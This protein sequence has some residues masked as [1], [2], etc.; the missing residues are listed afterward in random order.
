LALGPV[1]AA[2]GA[3]L[4]AA[5]A[6]AVA[7]GVTAAATAASVATA[8]PAHAQSGEQVLVL[9]QNGE[10]NAPE[11]ALLQAAGYSVTEATPSVWAGMSTA[12]FEGYAALVIGDPSSAG[13][14]S[15]LL[16]TTGTSGSDAL[17][18]AWQAAVNGNV[19]VLGTAP[20]LPGTSA[21]DSLITDSVEYAAAGWN[22]ANSGSN[23]SDTGL[24]VSLNCEYATATAGTD[25]SLLDGVEGIGT[26][27]GLT[28]QGN[29]ACGD[30]G[31]VNTWEVA[32]AGTYSGFTSSDLA[33][34]AWG[35]ACPVQEA[36][37]SWP[38]MFNPVAYDAASDVT[39]NFTASDGGTGQPYV[40]L[41][42]P[43]SSATAALAPSVGG[44]VLGGTTSGGT[45]NP[46]APGVDQAAAGD[47]VNTENGDFT[48]SDADLSLPGF[49]PALNFSR[50]YDANLAQQQTQTQTPGPMGY[51]WT[52]NWATS[53]STARPTPGDIY[54]AD[55]MRLDGG[56][57]GL[58]VGSL[59]TSPEGVY[60]ASN[61]DVY[62]ADTGDNRIQEIAASNESEWGINMTAN[63]V[64]TVAGQA[65]GQD[66]LPQ[67]QGHANGLPA[68]SI[69]LNHP[70]GITL[71][72]EG[73]LI[74]TDTNNARIVEIAANNQ[75]Q[76]GIS[77][78]AGDAYTIAGN[79]GVS[80]QGGLDG[81]AT[82][83]DLVDPTSVHM[84]QGSGV[85]D[86]YIADGSGNRILVMPGENESAEWGQS[87]SWTGGY[88]YQVAGDG[89]PGVC[90]NGRAAAGACL[91]DPQGV[92]I[93]GT[94]MYIAD[95][96]NNRIV[97]VPGTS[98]S[99][100]WGV[101]ASMTEGD[102]YTV[103][104]M[105]GGAGGAD[106]SGAKAIGDDLSLPTAVRD[107]N[108]NLYITDSGNSDVVEVA[109]STHSEWGLN[110]TADYLYQVQ[111]WESPAD[112]D[113][114]WVD[115][116]GDIYVPVAAQDCV[117]VVE[118]PTPLDSHLIAGGNRSGDVGPPTL[119]NAGDDG[120]AVN[121]SL[122][123]PTA[124]A[125]DSHGDVYIADA[126]NERV[127]EIAAY[128]HTQFGIA[129]LAGDTYTIAS[130]TGG[131]ADT[132]PAVTLVNPVGLAVDSSGDVYIADADTYT[133]DVLDPA[134]N[135]SVFAG[136]GNSG[137]FSGNGTAAAGATLGAPSAVAVDASGDV[138]I[139]DSGNNGVLEVPATTTSQMTAG[140]IYAVAGAA[141]TTPSGLS[142]TGTTTTSVSLSW[143]ASTGTVTGYAVYENGATTP[144]TTTSG[145][146]TTA[147]VTGLS[148]STTYTFTVAA[149]GVGGIAGSQST[150]VTATTNMLPPAPP[151]G[152]TVTGTTD[153]S[154]SLSW[155]APSGT[156]SGYNVYENGGS[157]VVATST[158]TSATVTGLSAST[159][160]TFTVEATNPGGSSTLSASVSAATAPPPPAAP[161]G[162]TV[163]GTMSTTVSLSWTAPSG[164]VTGYY[165]YQ[166][167]QTLAGSVEEQLPDVTV[168][169]TTAVVAGLSKSTSY[170]LN[171]AAYNV[172]GAGSYS[173]TVTARTGSTSAPG[174]PTGL[175]VSGVTSSSV[176][177]S[178]TAPSGTVTGYYVY[179]NGG[180]ASVASSTSTS[181]TVAGLSASTT[182]TFT[183]AAYN[184]GG[185]GTTSSSV[186][187][188]TS[189]PPVAPGAPAGL[190]VT[191]SND[192][193][194]SLSWTAPPGTVTGYYV[195]ENGGAVSV[196]ASTSTSVT[197]TG[198][199]VSTGYTF[200]VAAY[201]SAGTGTSSS[202]VPA[203]T[204]ALPGAPSGLTVTG[205]TSGSVS[206]SWT[207]PP[208]TV[209]GYYV[210]EN[211]GSTSVASS[212]STSVTVTGLTVSTTYTFTVA[213]YDANGAS[214]QSSP[215]SATTGAAS[216]P[217]APT[218]LT[219]TLVTDTSVS[220][221]WTAP[222]GTVTGYYVYEED[223]DVTEC[224]G[225][226][227]KVATVTGTGTT[228]SGLTEFDMYGFAVAAYNSAGTGAETSEVYVETG[229]PLAVKAGS[230]TQ[231]A[232][233]AGLSA[234]PASATS[235]TLT[236][237]KPASTTFGGYYVYE[238]GTEVTTVSSA[239]VSS[240]TVSGLA[241]ATKYKFSI[242]EY[243]G[244]STGAQSSPATATT[245]AS[246]GKTSAVVPLY[247]GGASDS[248]GSTGNGGPATAALLDGPAGIA[249]DPAG[250][251]YISDS[252]NNEIR[253]IAAATGTQHGQAMTAGDIYAVAGNSTTTVTGAAC[254]AYVSANGDQG[255]AV[256][257]ALYGPEQVAVDQAGDL[258]IADTGNAVIREVPAAS[259]TQ[260]SQSMTAG[261]IYDIAGVD[262]N[263]GASDSTG[264]GSTA[265][266]TFMN[267]PYGMS[268][269][270]YGDL[271]ILQQGGGPNGLVPQLQEI[272]ATAT[273]SIP[274]GSGQTSSLYPLDTPGGG[275][276]ITIAQPGDSQV[277]F[278]AQLPTG[279]CPSGYNQVDSY[280]LSGQDT[281]ATLTSNSGGNWVY[282]PTA[283]GDS[284]TYPQSGGQMISETDTAGITLTITQ[285]TPA[286]GS[287]QCPSTAASCETIL[288]A[289]GRTL[290]VGSS[291]A[292]LITS[293]TDPMGRS[294]SYQ[295]NSADQL[296]SATDPMTNVTSYTYGAGTDTNQD[297]ANDLLTIT[298]PNGQ[299]GGPDAG[300]STI[301][302]YDNLGRVV[303]Q[304]DPMG[305]KTSFNYCVNFYDGDCMDPASGS[306]YVTVTDPDNNK[307]IY[308]YTSGTLAS[309]AQYTAAVVTSEHDYDPL[310]WVGVP[311]GGTLLDISTTDGDGNTTTYAYNTLG[312]V[313]STTAP[314]PD[315]PAVTSSSYT[316][317]EDADCVGTPETP[318]SSTCVNDTGPSPVEP[319]G[320]IT[321]PSTG[322]PEGLAFTLYDTDGN[323]LYTTTG[324]YEPGSS[325]AAYFQTNYQLFNGNTVAL[326]GTTI[327]CA[328]KAPAPSLPCAQINA[329]Y[330]VTQLVYDA[331]GD[332]ISSST[333]DGNGAEIATSAN[334]YNADGEL[335]STTTPDGNLSGANA[336][337]Y[338]T[339][340]AYNADGEKT[341]ITQAGGSG[342]TATPRVITYTYDGD[343]DQ[344]GVK[345]G[346][347]YTTTTIY[348][349]DDKPSLVTN[350]D[351]DATL[352][353]YD[354]DGNTA[355]TVPPV[356]V[357]ANS[358]TASSCPT[359][360]PS[361]YGVRLVADAT[362]AT[363]NVAREQVQQATPAPAGQSG[364]EITTYAYDGAGNTVE[365]DAPPAMSGGLN[366]ITID[367]YNSANQ[368]A[369]QTVGYGISA[370]STTTFCYNPN[371]DRTAVVAPD[372]NTS[373]IAACEGASPWIVNPSTNP[374]Q[375]AY[376]TT[377]SYDSDDELVT[378]TAP[379]S[380][381][382]PNGATTTYTY[383][384]AG[385]PLTSTDPDNITTTYTYTP[386][387]KQAKI[388]Y[389]GSAAA[390]ITFSYDADGDKTA[391]TDTSGNST[392]QYDPFGELTQVTNGANETV[393]YNYDSD[394]DVTSIGYPLPSTATWAQ[395]GSATFGY[396]EADKLNTITD[397]SDNTITV[398]D[399]ADGLPASEKLGSSGDTIT[400][401][402]DSAGSPSTIALAN[403]GGTLQSFNYADA[404]SGNILT[405]TDTPSSAGTPLGYGYDAQGRVTSNTPGNETADDYQYDASGNLTTLPNGAAGTYNQAS[406]L[407]SATFTGAV[408]S[409]TYNADGE[410]LAV[411][412]GG[413]TTASGTWNGAKEVTAYDDSSAQMAGAT[414]DG[415][416]LRASA[417]FTPAN[418][419]A[420]T[421]SY[422]W[423]GDRLLMDSA[424]AYIYGNGSAPAEQVNL[425][426]GTIDY[427]VSD[428]L[429][430]VR[431][432]VNSSGAL[433]GTTSYDAWGNSVSNGGLK[434][435]TPFGFAGGYTD[436][437]GLVYLI[438]R[439]YDP[440]S[441]QFLSAD[442]EVSETEQPYAYSDDDPA[443]STDPSGMF[444]IGF[445]V[446]G[447]FVIPT[448]WPFPD[449]V[450][451]AGACLNRTRFEHADDIGLT[452]TVGFGGGAGA[453]FT[454]SASM[455]YEFSN[456]TTLQELGGPFDFLSVSGSVYGIGVGLTVF[457]G[458]SPLIYGVDFALGIGDQES[459][460]LG[461]SDTG[462]HQF[463]DPIIA[464]AAR[465]FWDFTIYGALPT[466][467]IALVKVVQGL[468]W[469]KKKIN[470]FNE[471]SSQKLR[472]HC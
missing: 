345:D 98:T 301:N 165:V 415:D 464:N 238:N 336:G 446:G 146:G 158:S 239:K 44:E 76:W 365:I 213:S 222:A 277:T 105:A 100:Q 139:A 101:G 343:G 395:S 362:V 278:Y 55:G 1:L 396:D 102:V 164:P 219:A 29:L 378:T 75:T 23:T 196:A 361:G 39:A 247:G 330:A 380:A 127:Q 425:T 423:G 438:N 63:D 65:D 120:A 360:Y 379:A 7:A 427:L 145:T 339:V 68:T 466:A 190:T 428:S 104:G 282:T 59:T 273:L 306:G 133:V 5:P 78:N 286:P 8:A 250:N 96:Q 228:F 21:S 254:P 237:T 409:Y 47:P 10:T 42:T 402:Y 385:N 26:D 421:E 200:T 376:Q 214:A 412:Q 58:G 327:S 206:L 235:V 27:G 335:T 189:A 331:A 269:D 32:K 420:V 299:S 15:S 6:V 389:S 468:E 74:I 245:P 51:G 373:G 416:G 450:A 45:S 465:A 454:Q 62:I 302:V 141:A 280:C 414:Y 387:G 144:V 372:G 4:P 244:A 9:V 452:G 377:Y 351:G 143:K 22:S 297:L 279:G 83:A 369:T 399:N 392:Y 233:P 337:N 172:S 108:G 225:K 167:E 313:T 400:T 355:Q 272:A 142:V 266:T 99:S 168:T 161:S 37:G 226:L 131:A 148:P 467:I 60:W 84:G 457:W 298:S 321:P 413:T 241:S 205:M 332:L 61:G 56:D 358:L 210:Y 429:G 316:D 338:T 347:G 92:T 116:S 174:A 41:G 179:E 440:I 341:T 318:S 212:S 312:Q 193:S 353:C 81:P 199:S 275:G 176:S 445:C 411:G 391:M 57:G 329:D 304:T 232:T 14:C 383:D 246:G 121:A 138:F 129:M 320:V 261:D 262:G 40:L 334:A 191:G 70:R 405:E 201:N 375:A 267:L 350:P 211:G 449:V 91:N 34:S 346:R 256:C 419:S 418:G 317:D 170:T 340:T 443:N 461:L 390:P 220:V 240:F 259:G 291:S 422:V 367:T 13:L 124:T 154:V 160:Y 64:Y 77:M 54:A 404:P 249:V 117:Y 406:E 252:G 12:A 251:I 257:A 194:V 431:G 458:G 85:S 73:D 441:G 171:V 25:V 80:G 35:T 11:A 230:S 28:V 198:L 159:T 203:T 303:T 310:T 290:V 2:S 382:D 352:T 147:T 94:N 394:G 128:S 357:A 236:W 186:P 342:A 442:P 149:L 150:S 136:T 223:C 88:L 17:G 69:V 115:S 3:M 462:V 284:Y 439:Y 447:G 49:G 311:S 48:Q 255:P 177:L 407:T 169:G 356:G 371:G 325:S 175:A 398:T 79:T 248:S 123:A 264:D 296:T 359:S 132:N 397:F 20:V 260:W 155:T 46:A 281:S 19:A 293:V 137:A 207:A 374:N 103:A 471:E 18:S 319:G 66:E 72:P 344:T 384:A 38:A 192:T 253:E 370:A 217:A 31:T 435:M 227:T 424:N 50:T 24:Y 274:A 472:F 229:S 433:T 263:D 328:A 224:D 109:G 182:Y 300:K 403:S 271:F 364:F 89:V 287:G 16:P 216:K 71:D 453:P 430:S 381:A 393:T 163:T 417:S 118:Q 333:P 95:T 289:S 178:W 305:W 183:V 112:L 52:D 460:D 354:G 130:G 463:T 195:Y 366:Q 140:D 82:S 295:Y 30:P 110:M 106:S 363:Y 152:L 188:T 209:T 408:T 314:S 432:T 114:L 401:G 309:E 97:E 202:S 324:V 157:T 162:L 156:V 126:G 456:A 173:S 323:E 437:D 113:D 322:P 436:P 180:S 326:S 294:W 234:T 86:L 426:T 181:V 218:N 221:S 67:D 36:F 348:N 349:A 184:S 185:T 242:A 215:A 434:A 258:Y 470:E 283:G 315:G 469:A 308:G 134:G 386:T 270:P 33:T 444:T 231:L 368:L 43:V 265:A 268:A 276:G 53:L 187:A 288:A 448:P 119:A 285:N 451:A 125:T 90:A 93:N 135:L 388:S 107:P 197:V 292:G 151:T 243:D 307:T 111:S 410:R 459:I 455:Y 153:N 166:V 87:G 208:G 204:T 122:N